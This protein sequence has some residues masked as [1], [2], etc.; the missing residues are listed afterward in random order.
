MNRGTAP[1]LGRRSRCFVANSWLALQKL[2]VEE[3]TNDDYL[4]VVVES[5]LSKIVLSSTR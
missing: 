2:C 1:K 5:W 4:K 3:K